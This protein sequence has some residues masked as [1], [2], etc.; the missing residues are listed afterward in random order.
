MTLTPEL[1]ALRARAERW[2]VHDKAPRL[3]ARVRAIVGPSGDA[4]AQHGGAG[5]LAADALAALKGGAEPT[6]M[7]LAALE[8][9]I[10]VMRPA[11]RCIAGELEA[12]PPESQGDFPAWAAFQAAVRPLLRSIGRIDD[13][14]GAGIGTG[15]LVGG[16]LVVT[17]RHVLTALSHGS[18]RLERGQ[19]R[20]M[21]VHEFN[22]LDD[23]PIAITGVVAVHPTLDA[24][25][26]KIDAVSARPPL[27]ISAAA[28]AA[29]TQVAAIGY[30]FRDPVRNPLFADAIFGNQYGIKRASPGEV[31]GTAESALYHDCSTLGGNSGSP[32]LSLADATVVGLHRDGYFTYRNE[33]VDGP[34]LHA[35]VGAVVH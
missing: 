35:F 6:P 25:L 8:T 28:A 7:Q 31:T 2:V 34:S 5:Q 22:T 1:E 12:L 21:F 23:P 27:T 16:D 14:N 13:M 20:V 29:G 18:D 4:L 15:F 32:I 24:V 19:A 26:L 33:A 17:N 11:P 3:M 9:M 30:P 10:R